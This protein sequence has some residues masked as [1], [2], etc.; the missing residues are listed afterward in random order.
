MLSSKKVKRRLDPNSYSQKIGRHASDPAASLKYAPDADIRILLAHQPLS[1]YKASTAGYDL[2]LSGHTHG[3]QYFPWS[4]LV[5]LLQ[6]YISGLYKHANSWVY[7][8]D[9]TGYWGPPLRIGTRSEITLI[10]LVDSKEHVK[11]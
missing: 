8:S 11:T 5:A 4:E 9:G 10:Q 6:P 2:Q 7:V 1:I 3:G